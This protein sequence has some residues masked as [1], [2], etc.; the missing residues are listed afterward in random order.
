MFSKTIITRTLYIS[1]E[2]TADEAKHRTSLN[3][4]DD[5]P[6]KACTYVEPRHIICALRY[7][8]STTLKRTEINLATVGRLEKRRN[9]RHTWK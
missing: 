9:S 4:V 2:N 5:L 7:Q 1:P 3:D 8:I 6:V